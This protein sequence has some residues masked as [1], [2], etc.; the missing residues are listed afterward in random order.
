M[1]T[2]SCLSFRHPHEMLSDNN[3]WHSFYCKRFIYLGEKCDLKN[4]NFSF[5][6][7]VLVT[8]LLVHKFLVISFAKYDKI[9]LISAGC[10]GVWTIDVNIINF[11]LIVT[12]TTPDSGC[13]AGD[14][15]GCCLTNWTSYLILQLPV[16]LAAYLLWATLMPAC[17]ELM[18]DWLFS[19]QAVWLLSYLTA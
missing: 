6:L 9:V 17:Q 4:E 8:F 11:L 7:Q 1:K 15:F 5:L 2:I 14:T 12:F 16:F 13:G 10:N 3:F 19:S 18:A